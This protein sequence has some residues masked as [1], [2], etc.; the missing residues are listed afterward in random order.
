[1]RRLRRRSPPKVAKDKGRY[2]SF[3]RRTL[4]LSG[5]MTAI[6]GVL[7]GRLYQLQIVD[8]DSYLTQAED[9]RISLRLLAPP[10]GRI[11][12]R[13]G[14]PLANSR[15]NY[16]VLLVPEQTRQGVRPALDALGKVIAL[17]DHVRARVLR[18]AGGN[19]PFMPIV[20]AENLSWDE[21]ARLN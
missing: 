16:R 7:A 13:F 6:F 17:D 18:E 12:D 19:K 1:M 11:F 14:V 5:G 21:F 10:R 3:T 15:R 8:G 4:L 2:A 9:N 20:V